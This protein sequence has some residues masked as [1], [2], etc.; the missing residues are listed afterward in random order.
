VTLG[1]DRTNAGFLAG[2]QRNAADRSI[3]A[4]TELR[5]ALGASVLLRTGADVTVDAYELEGARYDDPDSP[6][7]RR[8]EQL[9]PPRT[10]HAAGAWLDL[11]LDLSSRIQLTPGLRADLYGSGAATAIG[12]DPRVSVR[13]D[14]T[15]S[16]R[17]TSAFGLAHQAP[18]FVIP[19]PGISPA[20]GDGLQRSVQSSAGVEIALADAT[21]TGTT[22]FYN[23]F[24][25][26]TDAVGT[27][28]GEGAP[29]FGER[30][31]GASF[32]AEVFLRRRLTERF[33]GFVSYTLSRSQR[34][35]GS[36]QFLSAFDRPHVVSAAVS[37]D[38]GRGWRTGGRFSF[39]SGTPVQPSSGDT[40]A[41]RT[42]DME[43]EPPFYR[44]DLRLEKRWAV[45]DTGWISFVAEFMNATLNKE[46]WPGGEEIGPIAIPSLGL[47][48]GFE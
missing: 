22:L 18:S 6:E 27:S 13:F 46:T 19:V 24:F 39:Y 16:V 32:G 7:T 29:D 28:D 40:I 23:A 10:D 5:S 30:S 37:Y 15:R 14:L 20:L 12:V 34:R 1:Y 11:V 3:G 2:D 25:A 42:T 4:R 44:L 36:E 8:F 48:G 47:E 17:V 43:R 9:F 38:L 31:R 45:G 35:I 21:T 33:G 41:A 26:M